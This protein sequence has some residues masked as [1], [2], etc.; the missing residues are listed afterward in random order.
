MEQK[1]SRKRK[2]RPV[3]FCVPAGTERTTFA[4]ECIPLVTFTKG[5]SSFRNRSGLEMGVMCN[6]VPRGPRVTVSGAER[7][8]RD[9]RVAFFV[10]ASGVFPRECREGSVL[11]AEPLRKNECGGECGKEWTKDGCFVLIE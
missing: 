3:S 11:S 5:S 1:K 8:L 7:V 6:I 2:R 9:N 10:C 4:S